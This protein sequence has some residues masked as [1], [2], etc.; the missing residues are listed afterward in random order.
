MTE[1]LSEKIKLLPS[2]PGVYLMFDENDNV[3]YVGKAKNLKNR[4]KQYFQKSVK[5]EK[6][7]SMVRNIKDFQYLLTASEVDAL[8][9]ENNLIKKYKPKYN[10]LL[11]DDKTYPYIRVNLNENYPR[12]TISRRIKKD[13][14]KYFGPYMLGLSINEVLEVLKHA[15]QIRH[16][17]LNLNSKKPKKECLNYHIG[18]CKAPC[19][20]KISEEEYLKIVKK[21]VDF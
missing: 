5:T 15:Y 2:K 18:L 3:I 10:I 20:N 4:V 8:S 16:C 21:A 9:L 12:F 14:A 11:K 17:N 1:Q 13:G 19:A 7:L 6:V